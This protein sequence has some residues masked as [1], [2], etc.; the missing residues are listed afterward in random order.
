MLRDVHKWTYPIFIV[1][2]RRIK[3]MPSE[4]KKTFWPRKFVHHG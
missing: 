1:V 4:E 3:A 2:Q